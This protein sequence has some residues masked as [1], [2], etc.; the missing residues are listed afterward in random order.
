[1]LQKLKDVSH[2]NLTKAFVSLFVLV[3]LQSGIS[4]FFGGGAL[5][6][7]AKKSEVLHF[8]FLVYLILF[9][10]IFLWFLLLNGFLVMLYRMVKDEF[11]TFGFLFY[12][13]RRFRQFAPPAALCT[14]LT[15]AAS[16]L[17]VLIINIAESLNPGII[18][19]LS[20]KVSSSMLYLIAGGS[21]LVLMLLFLFPQIFLV[22]VRYS[23]PAWSV[24]KAAFVSA[25]LSLSNFFS[26]ILFIL[27]AGGRNMVLASFYF[28]VG[29][30]FSDDG[31]SFILKVLSTVFA[32]LYFINIYKA[33]TLMFLS[34]PVF[35]DELVKPKIEII[36]SLKKDSDDDLNEQERQ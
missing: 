32:L 28:G 36:V 8:V 33:V 12:G 17:M 4:A 5:L 1:M 24:F 25:K 18:N 3:M 23:N 9:A 14:V 13:F 30:T 6:L 31:T 27:R 34:V 35:Y 20:E 29:L 16:G 22:F 11:V 19:T 26:L 15:A 2:K 21:V 7:A 10:G